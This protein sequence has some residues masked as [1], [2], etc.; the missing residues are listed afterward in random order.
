LLIVIIIFLFID[1]SISYSAD[2]ID[3]S[4]HW[5]FGL[6]LTG[7]LVFFIG[8][9]LVLKFTKGRNKV[10][11]ISSYF[12]KLDLGVTIIQYFIIACTILL[13][14]QILV[15]SLYST[16]ILNLVSTISYGLAAFLLALLSILF[17]LWYQ[18]TKAFTILAYGLSAGAASIS[19]IFT[20]VFFMVLLFGKSPEINPDSPVIWPEYQPGTLELMLQNMY[21]IGNT[22]ATILLWTSTNILL[23]HHSKKFGRLKYW[24]LISL[25]LASYLAIFLVADK[26]TDNAAVLGLNMI[27]VIILGY[28]LP[29]IVIGIFTGL[30]FW[31]I[32]RS[33]RDSPSIRDYMLIAA[34]G[35]ILFQIGGTSGV[36]HTPF[37]PLGLAGVL[38]VGVSAYLILVGVHH[39]A[40]SISND[41]ELRKFVRKSTEKIRE[42]VL[43]SEVASAEVSREIEKR[44]VKIAK[45][46]SKKL[47]E[48]KGIESSL[49]EEDF[50]QYVQEVVEEL[51]H[52]P[53][54][55]MQ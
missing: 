19:M 44:V 42:S 36:N 14:I 37:P 45:D 38:F 33:I 48:Q 31:I 40:L 50:K 2:I 13:I 39:C 12:K 1:I 30:P 43:L 15:Q 20:L 41:V 54:E 7:V 6:F 3:V 23:Y 46:Q 18:N 11:R 32:G 9:Y 28:A 49:T 51:E 4:T 17:I 22:V 10:G 25:P 52:K 29:G 35:F 55:R 24:V 21:T 5:G 27:Y 8:Q 16:A 26:L 47:A 53:T 34:I